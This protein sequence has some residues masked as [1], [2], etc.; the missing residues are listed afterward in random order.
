[1]LEETVVIRGADIIE[2]LEEEVSPGKK[3]FGKNNKAFISGIIDSEFFPVVYWKKTFYRT[4]VRVK[5]LSGVDDVVP[6]VVSPL[7]LGKNFLENPIAGKWIEVAGEIDSYNIKDEKGC[8]H[9][10]LFLFAN[11]INICSN[12]YEL[13]E[14]PY[15]NI[16]YLNGYV[17]KAPFFRQIYHSKK[18]ITK[19]IVVVH[20]SGHISNYIPCDAWTGNAYKA[21]EL[22][23]GDAIQIYGRFQSRTY[24]KHYSENSE[25]GEYRET[26]EVSVST[27]K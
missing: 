11:E 12:E 14:A 25:E 5:R 15:S 13:K 21:A 24:F 20:S 2:R 22:N 6:I 9:V 10:H 1:M 8:N 17:C 18:P 3:I 4:E 16:V 19:I 26:Y 27:M 23:I 7:L